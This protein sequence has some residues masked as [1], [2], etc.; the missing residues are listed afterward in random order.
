MSMCRLDGRKF[1]LYLGSVALL[2]H[3]GD[4][5]AFK[6][7]THSAAA[8]EVI[9]QLKVRIDESGGVLVFEVGGRPLNVVITE[10]EA[11]RAII[12]YPDF[13]RAGVVGPD[14]FPDPLTGQIL[15]HGDE[16]TV[17]KNVM[18]AIGS[19]PERHDSWDPFESRKGPVEYRSIDFAT[20]M[21]E[22]FATYAAEDEERAQIIAFIIGYVSHGVGDSF[23]HTW[24]NELAGGAW[25]LLEGRGLWGSVSEEV[26]HVAVETMIDKLVP[27]D[28]KEEPGDHGGY[29][30]IRLRAPTKFL[31]EFYSAVATHSDVPPFSTEGSLS[32]FLDHYKDLNVYNGGFFYNY[33]NAQTKVAG[34]LR[35]WSKL[36][37][38]FDFVEDVNESKFIN[39]G[40]D[41]AELPEKIV[42][43]LI[44]QPNPASW[45]DGLTTGFVDCHRDAFDD[46]PMPIAKLREGIEFVAGINDR[47]ALYNEKARVIRRNWV[48]LAQCTS[49][50]LARSGAEEF[51][52]DNPQYNRDSCADI[53]RAGWED[54]GS[55]NGL[56]RGSIRPRGNVA[57]VIFADLTLAEKFLLDLKAAF[58]GGDTLLL[59]GSVDDPL[60]N[61]AAWDDQALEGKSRQDGNHRSLQANLLRMLDYIADFGFRGDEL[62]EIIVRDDGGRAKEIY[63]KICSAVRDPAFEQC[64]DGAFGPIAAVGR[65]VACVADHQA[66]TEEN[67]ATCKASACLE[68]CAG[69]I[70]N[71]T[72]ADLCETGEVSGCK[73]TCDDLFCL[74]LCLPYLGCAAQCEPVKHTT[75]NLICN[76]FNDD[77]REATCQAA[78]A[79][80]AVCGIEHVVCDAENL[81][82]TI[83]LENHADKLLEPLRTAC[84]TV[85]EALDIFVCLK[86]DPSK[87]KA[88]QRADRRACV[89]EL[90]SAQQDLYSRDEC[91][92]MYAEAEQTYDEAVA[93][94]DA[95]SRLV[96]ELREQKPHVVVNVAFLLEDL[97]RSE[98]YL[99]AFKEAVTDTR[100]EWVNNSPP[101]SSTQKERDAYERRIELLERLEQWID[102]VENFR[103]SSELLVDFAHAA[104]EAAELINLMIDLELIPTIEGPTAQDIYDDVGPSFRNSFLP[105]FNTLQGM[106]LAPLAGAD[107][108]TLFSEEAAS[109]GFGKLPYNHG[110]MFTSQ[111]CSGAGANPFCDALI[112]FDDP[113]CVDPSECAAR[114]GPNGCLNSEQEEQCTWPEEARNFEW[115]TGRSIVAWN[116][117]DPSKNDPH[118]STAFPFSNS[119]DSYTNLYTRIFRVPGALA[120]FASFDE[121]DAQWISSPGT[122]EIN[123]DNRTEG[124]GSLQVNGCNSFRLIS[125]QFNTTE[126][127]VVGD[128]LKVD[129]FVPTQHPNGGAGNAT[130]FVTVP[131]AGIYNRALNT[132]PLPGESPGVWSSLTWT[133]PAAVRTALLDDFARAQFSI[134]LYYPNCSS[135]LLIDNLRFD[136]NLQEREIF[137]ERGSRKH[138]VTSNPLFDF[139]T[140]DDWSA[141]GS[142]SASNLYTHGAASLAVPSGGYYPVTSRPFSTSELSGVTSKLSIDVYV[143][144]QSPDPFW[145]G[146]VG[147]LL[148]CGPYNNAWLGQ[149]E[150]RHP[151]YEEFNTLNFTLSDGVRNLLRGDSG[152]QNGCRIQVSVNTGFAGGVLL[153]N[154]GFYE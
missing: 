75:C 137:H 80:E 81:A 95:V 88:T 42:S 46:P 92:D 153:D 23:A 124:A 132:V 116:E 48:K 84:D 136:G 7:G 14:A 43:E 134:Q 18:A 27:S 78:A 3:A 100:T 40:L 51:D 98:E 128:Q 91:T 72:C 39:L 119:K 146:A 148:T 15:M 45:I 114:N 135:P 138:T 141:P 115:H 76:I 67:V 13:F 71:S 19:V 56:Y 74:E 38:F 68:H 77:D 10:P 73:D 82:S 32:Q 140:P 120:R 59:F 154:M 144:K 121:P 147:L 2:S 1:A 9:E 96:D 35:S 126:W 41:K 62:T 118:V 89:V 97:Q 34:T 69:P 143:P 24:V 105:F 102:D 5:A 142:L 112:S 55:P 20:A 117:Y 151:F 33:L 64:L 53:V 107:L 65:G 104:G 109:D 61:H 12:D 133:V 36:G 30:R 110:F 31:D 129:V 123:K 11:Y 139:E 70:P 17:M 145:Y 127:G 50:N 99:A 22:F 54:E 131:G 21:L 106:K 60:H 108:V 83:A 37:P 122:L 52:A 26:K 94:K 90:C 44:S 150:L 4:A 28:L 58:L 8:T 49:E 57:D 152:V 87:D 125:P 149:A 113:N 16:S 29:E 47:I 93:V 79:D 85:D 111:A 6:M 63:D 66:C 101:A 103:P 86:G 25:S 130:L